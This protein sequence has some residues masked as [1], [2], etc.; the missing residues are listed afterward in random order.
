MAALALSH[1]LLFCVGSCLA[2]PCARAPGFGVGLA[3]A[4]AS[5][6]DCG[7]RAQLL[8]L[9]RGLG[10]CLDVGRQLGPALECRR[11]P[12]QPLRG[13]RDLRCSDHIGLRRDHAHERS[14]NL[15][16][17]LLR[18]PAGHSIGSQIGF[19]QTD[20]AAG[21]VRVACPVF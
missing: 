12:H 9:C 4:L 11:K 19:R 3:R 2:V 7:I 8:R 5:G 14:C 20:R 15:V 21:N 17:V 18:D 10:V 13:A 1:L 16:S 6:A